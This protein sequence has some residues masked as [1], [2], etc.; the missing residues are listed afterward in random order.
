ME[1]IT[2][3]LCHPSALNFSGMGWVIENH[4]QDIT[5]ISRTISGYLE[6]VTFFQIDRQVA[7]NSGYFFILKDIWHCMETFFYYH[8]GIG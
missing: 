7:P 3:V 1:S 6:S 2:F 5:H 8:D 4:C